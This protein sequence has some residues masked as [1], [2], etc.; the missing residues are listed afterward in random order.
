MYIIEKSNI[1]KYKNKKVIGI[2]ITFA[3]PDLLYLRI[4]WP[5]LIFQSSGNNLFSFNFS[6]GI[7]GSIFFKFMPPHRTR[8]IRSLRETSP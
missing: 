2:K 7:K 1:V 4:T 5:N 8:D 6:V 3:A